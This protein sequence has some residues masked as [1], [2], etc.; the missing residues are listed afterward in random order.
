M[1]ENYLHFQPKVSEAT[2]SVSVVIS[3]L[4]KLLED[5]SFTTL[6]NIQG[7]D[8][9]DIDDFKRNLAR[10]FKTKGP[11]STEQ[12]KSWLESVSNV[13]NSSANRKRQEVIA[14]NN[15]VYRLL[16]TELNKHVFNE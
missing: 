3:F 7:I 13:Q 4:L 11:Q 15:I 9:Y 8:Q 14:K 5:Q 10:T 1:E 2:K 16:L 12:I 6:L